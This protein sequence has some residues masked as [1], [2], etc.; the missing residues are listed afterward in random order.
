[1]WSTGL[2]DNNNQ[3]SKTPWIEKIT[4]LGDDY[5]LGDNTT[6]A[7]NDWI[8][9]IKQTWKKKMLFMKLIDILEIKRKLIKHDLFILIMLL[10][11]ILGFNSKFSLII[12]VFTLLF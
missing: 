10:L 7:F 8:S 11:E 9:E 4:S 2:W 6:K 5:I 1:M 12:L 3:C